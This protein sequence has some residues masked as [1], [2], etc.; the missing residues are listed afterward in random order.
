MVKSNNDQIYFS[1]TAII[2]LILALIFIVNKASN[3]VD[4][5]QHKIDNRNLIIDSL[6]H[7]IDTLHW[8]KEIF[9]YNNSKNNKILSAIMFVESSYNNLAYNSSEDAVGCLQIRKCMV[10]D[11]NRILKR[12]KSQ[13][14]FK[15]ND[16]WSRHKS[17][18]MFEIYRKYYNLNTYEKIARGWNGG[19]TGLHKPSTFSYW[20]KVKNRING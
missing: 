4:Q 11:V 8:E 18:Q 13:I 7:E 20:N 14:K 9:D 3:K 5:L 6:N 16:R 10:D 15:Y 1:T 2:L 17:I 12:K 19:P